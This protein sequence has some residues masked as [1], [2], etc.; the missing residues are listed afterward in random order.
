MTGTYM[1]ID[2]GT[3]STASWTLNSTGTMIVSG[4]ITASR[5]TASSLSIGTLPITAISTTKINLGTF[6]KR[7]RGW[8]GKSQPRC[9]GC[10]RWAK[11]VPDSGKLLVECGRCHGEME[12]M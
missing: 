2:P 4:A 3:G 9:S 11:L 6:W 8:N 1:S 5:I 10:A 12:R 7:A